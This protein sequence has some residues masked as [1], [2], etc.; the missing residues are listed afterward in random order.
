MRR[1]TILAAACVLASTVAISAE[2][3]EPAAKP[4]MPTVP[5]SES[6]AI[7]FIRKL[8]GVVS[9]VAGGGV[10]IEFHLRGRNLTDGGL[11]HV[12]AVPGVVSLNLRDTKISDKG[13]A[14]LKELTAL[15]HLHL[16]RTRI[17]DAGVA[18]LRGL[19]NLVYLNLY[20]TK[21]TDKSLGTLAEFTKLKRLYVWNSGVTNEGVAR[22]RKKRPNL[23]VV[24][25]VD[26]S[27]F[28]A[29]PPQEKVTRPKDV[30]KW[31]KIAE[32]D[33]APP[34]SRL[35][36]NTRI[37]F[38]NRSKQPVKIFWISYGGELKLYGVLKPGMLRDQNT[39]SD[40]SWLIT[41]LNDEPIGYFRTGEAK[42]LAV[43]PERD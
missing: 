14:H 16:E 7:E 30:L 32:G 4:S 11:V 6:A 21:V 17:G 36:S 35:G 10:E 13:L 41:N 15:R 29:A 18:H 23:K 2:I 3:E 37:I 25:G 40:A 8:G 28:P 24:M 33:Q 27:K 5:V 20:A 42:A 31:L 22:L 34:K 43:I 1:A 38:E 9:P 12:A 39:F 19:K 26:L